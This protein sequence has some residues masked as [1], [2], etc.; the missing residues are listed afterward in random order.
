MPW[1]ILPAHLSSL[2]A[3]HNDI[4]GILPPPP[5]TCQAFRVTGFGTKNVWNSTFVGDSHLLDGDY[6]AYAH[7]HDGNVVY[8]QLGFDSEGHAC[9]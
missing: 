8:K 3:S 6:V 7:G 9:L 4:D 5:F 2:N 1:H